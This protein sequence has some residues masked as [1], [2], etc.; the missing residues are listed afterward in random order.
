M[1]S[2]DVAGPG[3]PSSAAVLDALKT[4]VDPELRKDVVALGQVKQLVVD[5]G[6]VAFTLELAT[7]AHPARDRIREA[8]EQAV[9][10]LPGVSGVAIT[11]AANVRAVTAPEHGGAPLPGVKNVIAVGAGKGGVGKTTVSVNLALAL[12]QMG[13]RVGIL[14]GDVYGPNVPLMF[15]LTAE[16][17]T[18]G[19]KIAPAEK[20]GVQVVSMAFLAQR[21][22]GAHLARPDAAQR[23]PAVLPRRGLEGPRLPDHGHAA[24]APATSPCRSARP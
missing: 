24:R 12:A 11:M 7:P 20:Y 21:R 17:G 13:C 2:E 10:A 3:G 4:V 1:S 15:G 14:D 23:H 22:S 6:Q 16:L 18:D 5:G 8:A 19:Q 9:G